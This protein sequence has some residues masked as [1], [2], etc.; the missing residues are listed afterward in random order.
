MQ[1]RDRTHA[2]SNSG[3]AVQERKEKMERERLRDESR[4]EGA[5]QKRKEMEKRDRKHE[6]MNKREDMKMKKGNS[7]VEDHLRRGKGGNGGN[8]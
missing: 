5:E 2:D 7:P 3:E 4:S 1:Q 6:N 8:R